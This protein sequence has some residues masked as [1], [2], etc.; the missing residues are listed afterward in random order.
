MASSVTEATPHAPA[1]AAAEAGARSGVPAVAGRLV[2]LDIFRGATIAG[3]ILVNDPGTWSAVYPP[4]EHAAWNG[5]TPT[6]LIFPFFLFIVGVAM[7]FSLASRLGRGATRSELARHVVLRSAVIFAIGLFLN[8]FPDFH[9]ATIRYAG[10]LQRIAICYLLAG[11]LLLG[12][13]R[14]SQQQTLEVR[15]GSIAAVMGALLVGYWVLLR[16]VPVPGYGAGNWSPDGNLAAYLDRLLMNGHLW[17]QTWDPEGFLSTLPAI[18]TA[19]SGVL[20]GVWLRS[21][22]SARQKFVGLLASGAAAMIVGRLLHGFFPINKNLWTSTY[23][24]FTSGFALVLLAVCYW[25]ADLRGWRKWSMPL[26]V[27]GM[28]AIAAFTFATFVAKC[29]VV[30]SVGAE[31]RSTWHG[32]VYDRFFQPL[33][34]P[35]NASL[36]FAFF[37]VALCWLPMWLL[38][39]RRI[40]IKV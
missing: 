16:F 36:M 18:A 33:A 24:I 35:Q 26:L 29:S 28:N 39:R 34:S 20:A 8:G 38:Y 25:I 5:W 10:V 14:R 6:D 1:N 9:L 13:A 37:F 15:T 23:V 4:L 21:E 27:F 32:W 22:R 11:L 7:V 19:L 12:T 40:F 17:Q 2:S 30:F 3:M 31:S